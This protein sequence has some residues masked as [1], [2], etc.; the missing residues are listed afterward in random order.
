[1]SNRPIL[2]TGSHR[3]GSTW[4]GRMISASPEV[5]YIHEPFNPYYYSPGIYHIKFD[6]PFTYITLENEKPYYRPL[7]RTI[8]LRYDILSAI[9]SQLTT[10][11]VIKKERE[12]FKH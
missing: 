4:V 12:N 2:V 3:S 5:F 11:D 1:M 9:S 6:H 7:K 10:M 8:K